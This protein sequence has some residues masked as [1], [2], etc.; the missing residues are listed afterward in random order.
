L[1]DKVTNQPYYPAHIQVGKSALKKASKLAGQTI[2]LLQ[3]M[4]VEVFIKTQERSAVDYLLEPIV[5]GLRR[6]MRER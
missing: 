3:G 6:G 5:S 4:Q 2:E 1:T